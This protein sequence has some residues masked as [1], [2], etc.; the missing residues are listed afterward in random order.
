MG[1]NL[2]VARMALL[3]TATNVKPKKLVSL[4][5][6]QASVSLCA[7]QSGNLSVAQMALRTATNVKLDVLVSK[8]QRVN[9]RRIASVPKNTNQFVVLMASPTATNAEPTVLKWRQNRENV[10]LAQS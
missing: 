2:Y 8:E 7:L 9:A 5:R 6:H 4:K 1:T 3:R 10:D